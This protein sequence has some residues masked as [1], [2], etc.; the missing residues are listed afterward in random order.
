MII[1][2]QFGQNPVSSVEDSFKAIVDDVRQISNSD[3]MVK[4]VHLKAQVIL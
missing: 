4:I 2:G 1:P 3:P